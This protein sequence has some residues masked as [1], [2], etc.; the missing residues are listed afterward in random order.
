[1]IPPFKIQIRF[2]DIDMLG[3]VNNVIYLSY[4][5]MARVHYFTY[6]VGKNW[7]WK[8]EGIVL[9][10]NEVEYL[11][12]IVLYDKP[13]IHLNVSEIGTKSFTLA[14][15]IKVNEIV[16]TVGSSTLVCFNSVT[17]QSIGIPEKMRDA[18]LKIKK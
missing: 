8:S 13:E 18:L 9:V 10:K 14:Y 4:F 11:K 2:S 15:E 17:N 7:D 12:P 3:H 16:H 1:M 5:E 6:L